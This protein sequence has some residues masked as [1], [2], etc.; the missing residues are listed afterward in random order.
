MK[1]GSPIMIGSRI[2]PTR[3]NNSAVVKLNIPLNKSLIDWVL[4]NILKNAVDS[5]SGNGKINIIIIDN[6]QVVFIDIYDTGNG[7]NK[8]QYKTIFKPGFTTK[9][10]G[11]GLGLSLTKRT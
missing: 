3:F 10:R 6:I 4:E 1:A 5:M 8:N 11:W 7:I 9:E 2:S